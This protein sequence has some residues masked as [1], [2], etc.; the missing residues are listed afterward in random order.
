MSILIWNVRGLNDKGRRRDVRDHIAR[1][2]PSMV[3][4]IETESHLERGE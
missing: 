2:N 4:F 3:G 1:Y